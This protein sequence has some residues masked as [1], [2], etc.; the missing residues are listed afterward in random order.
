MPACCPVRRRAVMAGELGWRAVLRNWSRIGGLAAV[1]A[2]ALCPPASAKVR[3]AGSVLP[4]GQSGFVSASGLATGTGSPHL[5][6]QV[7]LFTSFRFKNAM[8]GQ[9]ATEGTTSPTPGLTIGR[10]A[11]GVPTIT[12]DDDTKVW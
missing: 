12:A 9:P 11:F 4:P 1:A 2:L 8:L 5:T 6:D 7:D 3:G 10:D